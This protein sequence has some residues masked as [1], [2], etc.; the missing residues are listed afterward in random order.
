MLQCAHDTGAGLLE[1]ASAIEPN[2]ADLSSSACFTNFDNCDQAGLH[3]YVSGQH[4]APLTPPEP[5]LSVPPHLANRS[6]PS[7][8]ARLPSVPRLTERLRAKRNDLPAEGP[9]AVDVAPE[10]ALPEPPPTP[11]VV[12]NAAAHTIEPLPAL[13]AEPVVP[14]FPNEQ[15]ASYSRSS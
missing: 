6:E 14:V 11:V 4:V 2:A 9:P 12:D 13:P 8:G 1:A 10:P 7:A 5:E 3:L 15:A